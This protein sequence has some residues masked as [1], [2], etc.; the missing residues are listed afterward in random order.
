M[1]KGNAKYS[2]DI[3]KLC[4]IILNNGIHYSIRFLEIYMYLEKHIP[5]K[6]LTNKR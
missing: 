6:Y 1:Y 5:R 3:E 2:S 4:K